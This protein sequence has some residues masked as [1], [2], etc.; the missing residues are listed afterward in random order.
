MV[1]KAICNPVP[2]LLCSAPFNSLATPTTRSRPKARPLTVHSQGHLLLR[3]SNA[4]HNGFAHINA[5]VF[6]R[7]RLEMQSVAVAQH[8]LV[9]GVLVV[10]LLGPKESFQQG[11]GVSLLTP[12]PGGNLLGAAIWQWAGPEAK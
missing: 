6:L 11:W 3:H 4:R 12:V 9:Q 5:G 10:A 1:P 2:S 8:L 7:H